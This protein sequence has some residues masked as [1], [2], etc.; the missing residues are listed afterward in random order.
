MLSFNLHFIIL[1]TDMVD[2]S[3]MNMHLE[4]DFIFKTRTIYFSHIFL[5]TKGHKR[6]KFLHKIEEKK[7]IFDFN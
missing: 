4:V 7:P 2:F 6:F 5:S 3:E 1:A